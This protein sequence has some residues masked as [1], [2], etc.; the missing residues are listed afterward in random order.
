MHLGKQTNIKTKCEDGRICVLRKKETPV[1]VEDLKL[2]MI[3][4]KLWSL[5]R[6][7]N[8]PNLVTTLGSKRRTKQTS[9]CCFVNESVARYSSV[10]P[11]AGAGHLV[12]HFLTATSSIFM[13]L[14][15]FVLARAKNQVAPSSSSLGVKTTICISSTNSVGSGKHNDGST[16][17]HSQR[18]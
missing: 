17:I 7:L 1:P 11:A 5:E 10:L 2:A 16:A 3:R 18:M 13:I 8:L 9:R 12:R 14:S 15:V 6:E 4:V